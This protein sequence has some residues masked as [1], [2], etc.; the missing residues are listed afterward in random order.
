MLYSSLINKAVP[1]FVLIF[2]PNFPTLNKNLMFLTCFAHCFCIRF[3]FTGPLIRSTRALYVSPQF[4]KV[5]HVYTEYGEGSPTSRSSTIVFDVSIIDGFG[6]SCNH[7]NCHYSL[8]FIFAHNWFT[9]QCNPFLGI[10][11]SLYLFVLYVVNVFAM[12]EQYVGP[13]MT[14]TILHSSWLNLLVFCKPIPPLRPLGVLSFC[15]SYF[16]FSCVN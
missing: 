14:S 6:K 12:L 8:C 4:T 11:Y 7:V 1:R 15:Y 10:N 9:C 2:L 16:Y 5:Q 13:M 3:L